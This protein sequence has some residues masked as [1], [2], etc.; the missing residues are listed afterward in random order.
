MFLFHVLKDDEIYMMAERKSSDNIKKWKTS[1]NIVQ[2]PEQ[3]FREIFDYL[4]VKTIFMVVRNVCKKFRE[5]ADSYIDV[6][7]I[8]MMTGDGR[9]RAE[10]IYIFNRRAGKIDGFCE[11]ASICPVQ[12]SNSPLI[13][14]GTRIIGSFDLLV[15]RDGYCNSECLMFDLIT[16]K[17]KLLHVNIPICDKPY[18]HNCYLTPSP[19]AIL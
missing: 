8:F 13:F 1:I 3:I 6:T 15:I 17:W 11:K 19:Y 16:L 10:I 5:Y 2:L 14:T 4:G 12:H 18:N 9:D 7:G